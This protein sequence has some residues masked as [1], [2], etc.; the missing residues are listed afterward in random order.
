MPATEAHEEGVMTYECAFHILPTVAEGEVE[1]VVANIKT[2]IEASGGSIT[3]EEVPV[4]YNL[5]YEIQKSIDG[6]YHRF[7]TSYFGWVRFTLSNDALAALEEKLEGEGNMLRYMVVR[8][9][10][11]DIAR[12]HRVAEDLKEETPEEA[13]DTP[14]VPEDGAI[15][16]GSDDEGEATADTDSDT[17]EETK[18]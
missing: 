15:S 10:R 7:V 18:E 13:S 12:P 2:H 8:L 17:S 6:K 4:R 9:S 11:E 1:G 5:A 3:D 16:A 14:A